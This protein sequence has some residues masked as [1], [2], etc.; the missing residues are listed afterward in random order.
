VRAVLE[1]PVLQGQAADAADSDG[2][3]GSST[4]RR[5]MQV[6]RSPPG[7]PAWARPTLLAVTALAAFAYSWQVGSTVELYYAAAVRSMAHNWHDFVFGGFDPAGTITVDKLPGALWVQALSVRLFGVH[8]WAFMLPQAVEGAL[9]VLV[10]FH[11]VRRLAGPLAGMVAAVVLAASPA[12]MTLDRGNIPDSLMILL[13]VLAADATVSALLTGRWRS[14]VL[15]GFWVALAFQ[16]KMLEAWL[17]LPALGLAYLVAG[18]GSTM[19]RLG[20]IAALGATAAVVSL[21]YMTF[22]TLTPAAQRPYEDGSTTNSIFHQVFVYNGFSRVGQASP[23]ATL[24]HTLG[25]PLFS[26]AEPP[27]AA[28]RLLTAGY[29]RDTGWLLPAAVLAGAGILVARRR[30]PRTDLPRA[31]AVLWGTWLVVLAVVFTISTTMN[32]YYAAALSPAVAALLGIGG[33]LAW[34]YRRRPSAQALTAGVAL[35]TVGYAAWLLPPAGTGLPPWLAP[36]AA[37]L[38]LAAAAV[39]GWSLW[40]AARQ[41]EGVEIAFDAAAAGCLLVGMAVLLVPAAAS[42]SVVAKGLGPF[43]TPFQPVV[44]TEALH[45]VFAPQSS[46]PG[47]ADLEQVRHGAPALMAAQTSAVAAPFIY[48]TGDEVLPLGGFTGVIPSP[49]AAQLEARISAGF[50]HLA[51]IAKPGA[52]AGTAYVAAHC[53]RVAPRRSKGTSGSLVPTLKIFYCT[54]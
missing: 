45:T 25:T 30:R 1:G 6:W 5:R 34:E 48:A 40:R 52:T 39:L 31:G 54:G 14:A 2:L 3:E 51:L 10:L 20:R 46:P 47:L 23:N 13:V 42:A 37:A 8:L 44:V 18:R 19:A 15:A 43:D 22:V 4:W 17:V 35:V 24:G 49:T 16:A 36:L 53:L 38:G 28:N 29:G 9:T 33:A 7:Q 32:S 12:T 41:S 26:Q 50:F 11:A 21:S 27:P